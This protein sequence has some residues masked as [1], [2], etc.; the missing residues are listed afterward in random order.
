MF[1]IVTAIIYAVMMLSDF[2]LFIF[3]KWLVPWSKKCSLDVHFSRINTTHLLLHFYFDYY[4]YRNDYVYH[5]VVNKRLSRLAS[6]KISQSW[7]RSKPAI[8]E[9]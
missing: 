1:I 2:G 5:Y 3:V 8:Y 6:Y 7:Q 4:Y 9:D